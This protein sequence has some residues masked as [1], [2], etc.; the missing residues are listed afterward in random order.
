MCM[1]M[2]MYFKEPASPILSKV[3]SML[4]ILNPYLL[5]IAAITSDFLGNRWLS[6]QLGW[7]NMAYVCQT[8]LDNAR[9][10][11]WLAGLCAN[12]MSWIKI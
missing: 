7:K 6:G 12:H 3:N 9:C 8:D 1:V 4:P 11:R 5:V 10:H 2:G